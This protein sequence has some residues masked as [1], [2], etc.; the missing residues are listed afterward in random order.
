MYLFSGLTIKYV[1]FDVIDK[2]TCR[3]QLITYRCVAIINQLINT[4]CTWAL[5]YFDTLNN[6]FMI[7]TGHVPM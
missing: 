6:R 5:N 2:R 7:N 4:I 3:R 1:W